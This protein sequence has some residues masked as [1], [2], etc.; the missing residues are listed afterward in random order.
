MTR[1]TARDA[2]NGETLA[3]VS[4]LVVGTYADHMGRGPT[5]AHTYMTEGIVVCLMEDTMTKAERMLIASG[6]QATVLETRAMFQETMR[7]GLI[8][9]VEA[10]IGRRVRACIG[11]NCLWP[12]LA[13]ELFI[14]DGA[15]AASP[16]GDGAADM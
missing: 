14:V 16:P 12:D 11:G 6:H 8:A 5:K 9:G 15:A 3:A 10:Q 13:S 7:E 2:A 4:N 1:T